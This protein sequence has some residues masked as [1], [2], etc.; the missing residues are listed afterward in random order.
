MKKYNHIKYSSIKPTLDIIE[1][2]QIER[3]HYEPSISNSTFM[4]LLKINGNDASQIRATDEIEHKKIGKEF[5][6]K[7]SSVREYLIKYYCP[8]NTNQ[9]A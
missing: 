6:Y 8:K 7:I 2:L 5:H 9:D 1:D 4:R 3:K